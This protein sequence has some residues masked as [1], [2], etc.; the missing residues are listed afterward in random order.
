[1]YLGAAPGVGK[2]H[3]MLS[4][5]VRRAGRGTHVAAALVE[6]RGRPKLLS[7][8][9]ELEEIPPLSKGG[10]VAVDIAE[11]LQGSPD[12]VLV[13]DLGA[14]NPEGCA[15]RHR[16][17]DI[18]VLLDR[19]VDVISTVDI[20]QLESLTDVVRSITGTLPRS[21]VPDHVVRDADQVELVDMTPEALRRR[22]AH[23]NLYP[24]D[25]V[26]ASI[27]RYY[28]LGNLTALRE[29]ALLWLADRVDEQLDTYRRQHS[30]GDVWAARE[31]VVVAL[32]GGSGA[33]TLLRRGARIASRTSG[34]E[35]HAVHVSSRRHP[36]TPAGELSRLRALTEELGGS[37]HLVIADDPAASVLDLARGLNATHVVVGE[38]SRSRWRRLLARGVSEQVI[39][40]AGDLDVLIVTHQDKRQLVPTVGGSALGRRRVAAGWALSVA[41]PPL[42]T[43][44]MLPSRSSENLALESMIFF[45]LTVATALVGGWWP[46]ALSAVLGSL[47]LN[48]FFTDPL[49]TLTVAATTNVLVLLVFLVVAGGVARVVDLAA[50]RSRRAEQLGREAE[51]LALLNRNLLAGSHTVRGLLRQVLETFGA[52]SATLLRRQDRGHQPVDSVGGEPIMSPAAADVT[53]PVSKDLV[54]ALQGTHPAPHEQRVLGAFAT[55]LKAAADR[56]E[57]EQRAEQAEHLE[58]GNRVRTALLSAVSHDLRTP[59][60]GV[61]AAVS[62]LRSKD[63]RWSDADRDEL[64]ASIE[65]STDRLARIVT[66][67]LDLSRVQAD[68]VRPMSVEVD[69]A[70]AANAA[71]GAVAEPG[72]VRITEAVAVP[73]A[74][75]DPG[76]IERVVAN[77]LAN[78]LAHAPGDVEVRISSVA[79]TVQLRVL[80]RGP[81]VPDID[82]ER[83][84]T[85]FQRLGDRRRTGTEGL[86]LGLA[87]ARGLVEAMDGTLTAE[88]TPGGGLTMVVELPTAEPD[89]ATSEA[90]PSGETIRVSSG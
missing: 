24:P 10:T 53:V 68:A 20:G 3:A 62:S 26:D 15:R 11:V 77:L 57:L 79:D 33:Q 51:V 73:A 87:V 69:L 72:R 82:K 44:A 47:L 23:G 30:I 58:A 22:L 54:L 1:M 66:N 39:R 25:E 55:H 56:I 28:R 16:W 70:E 90:A 46:A 14:P 32:T 21:S 19:G 17:E 85:A 4:E 60:A 5:G 59:L 48:W 42:L 80:D 7:L 67:L 18:E 78:A 31:R 13:D 12:V 83:I 49:H 86:G 89:R 64:L 6:T 34:G 88:D 36:S 50:S 65:D 43:A 76:L 61:K 2:T 84:F 81:G 63:I 41:G 40:G 74:I 71:A 29:L 8:L 27:S 45:A 9:D 35:L 52:S 75:A 37:Y 38:S